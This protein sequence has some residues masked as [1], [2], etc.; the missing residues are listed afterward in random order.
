MAKNMAIFDI[1]GILGYCHGHRIQTI[2]TLYLKGVPP[3]E[4]PYTVGGGGLPLPGPPPPPK[5]KEI[6][7]G[8]TNLPLEHSGWAI[9]GTQTFGSQDGKTKPLCI[10]ESACDLVL[11]FWTKRGHFGHPNDPALCTKP[12]K[13]AEWCQE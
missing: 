11:L 5:T 4:W 6:I 10:F 2:T 13:E 7:V 8:K 9:F 1:L 12:S 3:T